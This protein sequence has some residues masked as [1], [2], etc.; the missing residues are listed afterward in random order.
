MPRPV[1]GIVVHGLLRIRLLSGGS[2]ETLFFSR[3][4]IV[5]AC[6]G[7]DVV[8]AGIF[9][10]SA[11]HRSFSACPEY[12]ATG[13][14]RIS[15]FPVHKPDGA[16]PAASWPIKSGKPAHSTVDRSIK[17]IADTWSTGF[18]NDNAS[19]A[20]HYDARGVSVADTASSSVASLKVAEQGGRIRRSRH[21]FGAGKICD[22]HL[23]FAWNAAHFLPAWQ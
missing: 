2:H 11:E 16:E 8:G 7:R 3:A 20:G 10:K 4:L 14:K 15:D 13:A 23:M 6:R 5:G 1:S 21:P 18:A 22:L 9:R 19:T 12:S 17:H